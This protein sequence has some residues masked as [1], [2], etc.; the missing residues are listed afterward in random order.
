MDYE[1]KYKE[2]LERAKNLYKDAIDMGENIRAKQCEIIFP[3]LKESEDD[4]YKRILHS[5]TNKISLH[6]C[7]IFTEEEY[8]CFDAWSNAWL[9][10]QGQKPVDKVEPKFHEGDWITNGE[11]STQIVAVGS[12]LYVINRKDMSEVSLS[13]KY[14]EKWYHLWTIQDAKDGD[15]LNSPSHHLIWI[16]KDNE[17]Y[18]A[19]V[20]MNYVTENVATNGL[21][22]IPN[23][24]CPATKD[25]RT[26]LFSN[27]EKSGY[28]WNAEKKELKLLITNGGDF[29]ESENCEQKHAEWS[30]EDERICKE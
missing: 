12:G 10:K 7:D 18:H 25:E 5:I 24:A 6:L 15:V 22:S 2:A 1:K 29:F 17:N 16:Y 21:I 14:V 9:E 3:E 23:D 8:Q 4:R 27:V 20:N 19:C 28:E 26:I 11:F 13:T 30:E